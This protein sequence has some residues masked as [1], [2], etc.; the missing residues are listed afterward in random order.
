L[1]GLEIPV[2]LQGRSIVPLL[3]NPSMEWNGAAFSQYLMGRGGPLKSG[4]EERMGYAI[5]TERYRYVEWYNW[6]KS[7]IT[8][9]TIIAKELYDHSTDPGENINIAGFEENKQVVEKLSKQ[10]KNVRIS[11]IQN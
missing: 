4:K 1:A 10:L 2:N 11:D 6:N 9:S 5:R 3:G 8:D 7:K